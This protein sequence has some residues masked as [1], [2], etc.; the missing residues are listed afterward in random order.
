MTVWPPGLEP[1][2]PD[3]DLGIIEVS[4]DENAREWPLGPPG[5]TAPDAPADIDPP[6]LPP[7]VASFTYTPSVPV[8]KD[9]VTFDGSASAPGDPSAP[10]TVWDWVVNGAPMSGVTVTWTVPNGHGSYPV[11]LTVT[12]SNG[13]TDVSTQV[14][15]V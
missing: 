3:A 6:P 15:T 8:A 7:P 14:I 9:V 5:M 11:T 2:V 10:I 4:G 1:G 13:E 12:D